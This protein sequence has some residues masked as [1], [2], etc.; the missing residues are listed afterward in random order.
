MAKNFQS[1]ATYLT[2]KLLGSTMCNAQNTQPNN[3]SC[4]NVFHMSV[5]NAFPT[6]NKN[7]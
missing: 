3:Q 5:A 6:T 2:T 7:I 1:Y 4:T